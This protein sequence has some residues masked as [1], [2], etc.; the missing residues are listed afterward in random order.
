MKLLHRPFAR[1]LCIALLACLLC[2]CSASHCTADDFVPT[3]EW[4]TVAEGQDLPP[5]LHI[6]LNITSG[7]KRARLIRD[8]DEQKDRG[9]VAIRV[10]QHQREASAAQPHLPKLT[11]LDEVAPHHAGAPAPVVVDLHSPKEESQRQSQLKRLGKYLHGQ[12]D[13]AEFMQQLITICIDPKSS[14][15]AVSASLDTLETLVHQTDVGKDFV[16]IGGLR[17]I[18]SLLNVSTSEIVAVDSQSSADVQL[19]LTNLYSLQWRAAWVLGSAAQNNPSVKESAVDA[20]LVEQMTRVYISLMAQHLPSTSGQQ[21]APLDETLLAA[22]FEVQAKLLYALSAIVRDLPIAQDRFA[23][24]GGARML[25][26]SLLVYS[27]PVPSAISSAAQLT[28]P[29]LSLRHKLFV[30]SAALI[31]DVISEQQEWNANPSD[32]KPNEPWKQPNKDASKDIEI[33]SSITKEPDADQS[34]ES[35]EN[36]PTDSLSTPQ[37]SGFS[38]GEFN[39]Q[40]KRFRLQSLLV[41]PPSCAEYKRVLQQVKADEIDQLVRTLRGFQLCLD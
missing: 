25:I 28:A 36:S 32:G 22:Q 23:D 12:T 35:F 31:Q 1:C 3:E 20:N 19:E 27:S 30:K 18:T 14:V 26:D 17:V 2:V 4:Q 5:G 29:T 41:S 24:C 16:T 34:D 38:R 10:E 33:D 6:Q 39:R 7:K 37:S 21:A 8:E 15:E 9:A 13:E 11:V 40:L